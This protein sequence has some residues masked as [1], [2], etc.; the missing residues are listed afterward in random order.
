[1]AVVIVRAMD[2]KLMVMGIERVMDLRW[3][4]VF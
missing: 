3:M 4:A 2:V 1:M